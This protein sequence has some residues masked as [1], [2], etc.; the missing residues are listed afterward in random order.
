MTRTATLRRSPGKPRARMRPGTAILLG[1]LTA[2][3][4]VAPGF[5]KDEPTPEETDAPLAYADGN[6]PRL[7]VLV[8]VDQLRG[9]YLD[10]MGARLTGGLGRIRRNSVFFVNGRH[11]HALLETAPGHA[12]LASGRFPTHTNIVSNERG[13][14]DPAYPVIDSDREGA[15]P[16]R[17]VG[18]ALYDWLRAADSA[19]AAVTV[20]RKDRSAILLAGRSPAETVWYGGA[21]GFTRSTWYGD[22]VPEWVAAWNR[23]FDIGRFA[24]RAWTLSQPDSTYA[25]P[26]A[27]E[28]EN[29]GRDFTFPHRLPTAT[30]DLPLALEN[31]PWMDSLTLSVALA[32]VHARRLGQRGHTDY[33][34]ISLSSTDAVGHAY[35]P[36]SREIEDQLLRLD[37][38]LGAFLDSLAAAV[39][40][41]RTILALSADHG[42]T[43]FPERV[44]AAGGDAGRLELKPLADSLG[45]EWRR[46]WGSD[47]AVSMDNGMLYA[48]VSALRAR[49]V[50]LDSLGAAVAGR[51][52]RAGVARVLTRA[53]LA[54]AADSDRAAVLWRRSLPQDGGW[55]ATVVAEPGWM[56]GDGTPQAQH[57]TL[58]EN[59]QWVPIAFVVPGVSPRT[60][61]RPL[62]TVDVAPT[63]AALAGIAPTEPVDGRPAAEVLDA[64][65]KAQ[66]AGSSLP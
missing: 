28:W 25:A 12:T 48:D 58:S 36:D 18:T 45:R 1:A 59:D 26:D 19:A 3:G 6:A 13:V 41:D 61:E 16:A 47:F 11:G 10:R 24:G 7:V 20:S 42:V 15:S 64:A 29:G 66:A 33:L 52:A 23:R 40:P 17:F 44:L 54:A 31:A 38:W 56:F 32:G 50:S 9:D 35:G 43:S 14:I 21:H 49:G 62:E 8:V 30:A 5:G 2:W 27:Q 55:L 34:G 53:A 57:G 22:A 39:P 51:V 37:R 63:L 65:R 46:R 4:C 60:L